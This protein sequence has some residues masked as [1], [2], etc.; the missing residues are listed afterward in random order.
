MSALRNL[1]VPLSEKL[2]QQLREETHRQNKPATQLARQ[3][4]ESWLSQQREAFLHGE[5]RRYAEQMAGTEA[6]LDTALEAATI[7]HL[8]EEDST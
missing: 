1:H 7:E 5:I 4:I 6:D 2:Y 8:L 3:A